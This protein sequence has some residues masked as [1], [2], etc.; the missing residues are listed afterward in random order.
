MNQTELVFDVDVGPNYQPGIND[1][2]HLE[3]T[4]LTTFFDCFLHA[5]QRRKVSFFRGDLSR[6]LVCH[7]RSYGP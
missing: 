4:T 3:G 6:C 1:R 5:V 2:D 7:C